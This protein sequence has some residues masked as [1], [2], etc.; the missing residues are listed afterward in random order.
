MPTSHL[1]HQE[2]FKQSSDKLQL[3]TLQ[4]IMIESSLCWQDPVWS[5]ERMLKS[6]RLI[7]CKSKHT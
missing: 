4:L 2:L 1:I 3:M 5:R 7:V 6:S